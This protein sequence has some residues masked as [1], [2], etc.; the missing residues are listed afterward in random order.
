MTVQDMPT[1]LPD[2]AAL[3]GGIHAALCGSGEAGCRGIIV[4]RAANEWISTYPAEVVTYRLEDGSLLRLLCKY[5]GGRPNDTDHRGGV[6]YEAEVYRQV[7]VPLQVSTPRFLGTYSDPR[8]GWTWLLLE[9]LE[10]AFPLEFAQ[11]RMHRAA[12]WLGRF[13]AKAEAH[14]LAR[15]P[16]FLRRYDVKYYEQWACRAARCARP[17]AHRYQ[18]MEEL[19]GK[20]REPFELLASRP[21]TFVHGEFTVHNVLLDGKRI[22]PVDWESAAAGPGEIDLFSLIE[23]WPEETI[24][25]CIDAYCH[26]RWPDTGA[27]PDFDR[28]LDAAYVHLLLRGLGGDPN[29]TTAECTRWRFDEL[30]LAGKRWGLL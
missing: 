30:L 21:P 26:S 28:A 22:R 10:D 12:A 27:P 23:G 14:L 8:S 25:E 2:D 7:L 6:A 20:V 17:V 29:Y 4:G 9:H 11:E 3:A 5:S 13:H 1:Q 15:S 18:W 24:L 16:A 19:C